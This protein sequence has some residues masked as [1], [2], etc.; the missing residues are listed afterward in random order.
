LHV[1]SPRLTSEAEQAL[2]NYPWPGNIREL[3]NVIHRGLLVCRENTVQIDDL[4][5]PAWHEHP[6]QS[7][8]DTPQASFIASN[9]HVGGND[10]SNV[11]PAYATLLRAWHT[12][13]ETGDEISFEELQHQ[14]IREAWQT[15]QGN[16]VRTAKQLAISRNILRTYLKKASLL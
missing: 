3:E 4:Y 16:Q 2:V 15:N 10:S 14:L 9:K 8:R 13:L 5:L 11:S 7:R 12:V 6:T 1:D